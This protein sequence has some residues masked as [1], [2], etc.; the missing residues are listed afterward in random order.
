MCNI[1]IVLTVSTAGREQSL[2]TLKLVKN[3]TC[4]YFLRRDNDRTKECFLKYF[5]DSIYL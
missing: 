4:L 3:Q 2:S 5:V 1:A